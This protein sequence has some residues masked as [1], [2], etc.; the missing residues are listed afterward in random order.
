MNWYSV[1]LAAISGGL[2]AFIGTL[3]FGKQP[4]N[5]FAS[6]AVV[7]VMFIAL[8][9]VSHLFILPKVNAYR[10]K[11]DV[12]AGLKSVPAFVSI[13]KYAPDTYRQM[14]QSLTTAIEQGRSPQEATALVRTHIQNFVA[15]RLPHASD[16]ALVS[17]I[18]IMNLEMGELQ[19]K[20][21][22]MCHQ[23]LFPQVSGGI[24]LTKHISKETQAKDLAALDEIVKTSNVKHPTP[25]ETQVMPYLQPVLIALHGKYGDGVSVIENP[26][27]PGVDKE[28]VCSVTRDLYQKIVALPPDQA[29][30]VL[31]WMFAQK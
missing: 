28:K 8:M 27:A 30:Q 11:A 17:Y 7:A 9:S 5:K 29:G 3:I 2:A 24:D 23:F 16:A 12:A 1:G 21:K 4:D 26:T 22:G 6:N 31:R 14:S 19:A 13:E 25:P 18:G 20:Q 15:A 10:A